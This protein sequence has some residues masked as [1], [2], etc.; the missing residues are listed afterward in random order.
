MSINA[1]PEKVVGYN[2]YLGN[3]KLIGLQT[4][5]TLPKLEQ[6]VET[7]SG[8]GIAGE[9]ESAVPG[10]FGKTE[11][12]LTFNAIMS[13][14]AAL[15]TPGAKSLVLRAC[16]QSYDVAGGQAQFRPLKISLK[17]LSKGVD[18]GKL[19]A[20]KSTGTK[21]SFEV[22]YMKIEENGETL[23]E[24]DKLNFIFIVNGVDVLKDIRNQI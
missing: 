18:L 10:H 16:Q 13:D 14:S 15:L 24:M 22:L 7:V 12:D 3:N 20:G 21:Y 2:C 4:D 5:A 23:L 1:I 19:S 8:A 9:Y 11:M 6:M 17:V